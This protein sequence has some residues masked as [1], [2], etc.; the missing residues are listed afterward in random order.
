MKL[1][2]LPGLVV[3][4]VVLLFVVPSAVTYYTDWLWFRELRYEGIFLRTLNAQSAVFLSTFAAVFFFI[5]GNLIFARRRATDRPHIVLGAHASGRP[6][7][8]EGRRVAG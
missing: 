6:I 8:L 2:G 1:R 5:Y 4:A 3:L 7:A